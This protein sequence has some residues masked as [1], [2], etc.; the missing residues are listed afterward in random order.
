MQTG[1]T[2][3]IAGINYIVTS[4]EPFATVSGAGR[5]ICLKRPKGKKSYMVVVYPSGKTGKVIGY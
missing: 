2:M 1:D 4:T 3:Q 5:L